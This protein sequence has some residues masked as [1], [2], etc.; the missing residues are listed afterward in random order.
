[1]T[2]GTEF[3]VFLNTSEMASVPTNDTVN[4]VTN[5]TEHA[6]VQGSNQPDFYKVSNM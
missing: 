5:V 3:G 1:M 2:K 6:S 4:I